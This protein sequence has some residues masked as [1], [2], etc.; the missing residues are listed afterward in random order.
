MKIYL[1]HLPK[2]IRIVAVKK[3][4]LC[5][6]A[7]QSIR[8]MT[9]IASI[10]LVPIVWLDLNNSWCLYYSGTQIGWVPIP[11]S[12]LFEYCVHLYQIVTSETL[13]FWLGSSICLHT[14]AL[15]Y[16][17]ISNFTRMAY[18]LP[19]WMNAAL[20]LFDITERIRRD[21]CKSISP[22]ALDTRKIPCRQC[23]V[24]GTSNPGKRGMMGLRN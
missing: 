7:C 20:K 9:N 17:I 4:W 5:H 2:D 22:Q 23:R 16:I 24:N 11:A 1:S 13:W 12:V 10:V 3:E 21:P 18:S 6:T 8:Q 19:I 14:K 15:C